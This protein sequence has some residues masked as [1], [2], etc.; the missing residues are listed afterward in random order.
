MRLSQGHLSLLSVVV[1]AR[2]S[3][4]PPAAT[5]ELDGGGSGRCLG[6]HQ[7][8]HSSATGERVVTGRKGNA[9]QRGSGMEQLSVQSWTDRS[10]RVVGQSKRRFSLAGNHWHCLR[11]ACLRLAKKV[12]PKAGGHAACG[13]LGSQTMKLSRPAAV[14]YGQ[15]SATSTCYRRQISRRRAGQ[16]P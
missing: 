15:R 16:G 4:N 12:P 5:L 13:D 3:A 6:Q 10:S 1:A 2:A 11:I 8:G 7:C 14:F 9:A